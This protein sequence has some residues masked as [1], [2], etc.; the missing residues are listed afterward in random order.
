MVRVQPD[1]IFG[2][3]AQIFWIC[4]IVHKPVVHGQATGIVYRPSDNRQMATRQRDFWPL[5]DLYP[6]GSWSDWTFLSKQ[7]AAQ[8]Q[9]RQCE[10]SFVHVR[11]STYLKMIKNEILRSTDI[12]P[13]LAPAHPLDIRRERF[14]AVFTTMVRSQVS[15]RD[16]LR[17]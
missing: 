14:Y 13:S 7:I 5:A 9:D 12:G 4:T 16:S 17:N 3:L 8:D 6:L 1:R 15:T 10:K 2:G 11:T